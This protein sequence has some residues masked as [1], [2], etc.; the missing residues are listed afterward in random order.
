[1]ANERVSMLVKKTALLIEKKTNSVLMPHGL[2]STQFRTLMFL[3]R[4]RGDRVRQI[5]LETAFAMTNPT[6]TGILNNLEKKGLI[7]RTEN[8][9]DRRSKLIVLTDAALSM[10]PLLDSLADD[11]ESRVTHSLSADEYSQLAYLLKK[12]IS[13]NTAAL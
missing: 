4:K 13:D 7:Q 2:T 6:V 9:D 8:P 12:I 5:D 10:M 3:Y 11:A 1:M